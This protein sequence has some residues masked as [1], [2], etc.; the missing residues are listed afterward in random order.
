MPDSSL[1]TDILTGRQ[2]IVAPER[3]ARPGASGPEPSLSDPPGGDPF[4]E[5]RE[6]DTPGEVLALRS[7]DSSANAPGWLLRIVPNQF[8]A[9]RPE[10]A[11]PQSATNLFPAVS[12]A[13]QHEVVIESPRP[14]RRLTDLT[15][16]EAARILLA[17]KR[18]TRVLEQTAPIRSVVAFRNEGFSAGASLPHVHSQILA[19]NSVPPETER[20]VQRA[21][22]YRRRTGHSLLTDLIEAELSQQQRLIAVTDRLVLLCPF[23]GRTSWQVRCVL[24][25]ASRRFADTSDSD[26]ISMA[27]HLHAAAGALQT[28]HRTV[29]LNL[30]L[31]QLPAGTA[32]DSE[33]GHWYLDLLPRP[34][35]MAGFE[36][37]TD[38]DI[39]TIAPEEAAARIRD[40]FDCDVPSADLVVPGNCRWSP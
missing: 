39:V 13:G 33:C 18:R 31:V 34:A 5:G 16:P 23:A 32:P 1:R 35:R 22:D 26:L 29:A 10:A 12:A 38:V 27:A 17:W 15:V 6:Q 28:I 25:N 21:C 37:A 9:V 4:L 19:L 24:R 40:L 7:V 2:V 11:V 14:V 8:P 30:M 36:L 20:R 3:G